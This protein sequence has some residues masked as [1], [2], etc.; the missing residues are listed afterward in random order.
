MAM[1]S[2]HFDESGTPDKIDTV[3]TVAGCVS[4]VEK[5][6][7]FELEWKK[8]LKDAGLPDGTIF[9]MNRFARGLAPYQEWAGQSKRKAHLVS[10][11]VGC[12]KRNV[13]KA[14]SCSVV[15]RDWERLNE[16]YCVAEHLG[17][18]YPLCGRQC[19][20]QVMKWARNQGVAQA[21]IKFF[22]EDGATHRRQLEKFLRANDGI[23]P[24]FQS[25]EEMTQFQAADLLAWKSRKVLTQVVEYE[26]PGDIDA[27][28]SVQ[29]SLA[30][31]KSIP[32]DYGAH[33]YESME[34]LIHRAKIPR[35]PRK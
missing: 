30:E 35:R 10:A 26:G 15:L 19:I 7:R 14:F 33:V 17:Y 8:I 32:H 12:T 34:Q 13:N 25:K 16:R 18:P 6:K 2:A 28:N 21:H 27:Y 23:G 4:S 29:R 9:H 20:S 24:L 5:W 22:F 1:F 31:I 11:L 3:L